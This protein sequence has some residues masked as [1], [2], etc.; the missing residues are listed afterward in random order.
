VNFSTAV[1]AFAYAALKANSDDKDAAVAALELVL[2][3]QYSTHTGANGRVMTTAA[4]EGK[5]FS[6]TLPAN[7]GPK[8]ITEI[9]FDAIRFLKQ[10]TLT[11]IE[12]LLF[13]RRRNVAFSSFGGP[14]L[15]GYTCP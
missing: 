5:S 14:C 6:Y 12:A 8:E 10:H 3:G 13:R 9:T 15:P 4:S 1:H 2:A 11:E 7:F